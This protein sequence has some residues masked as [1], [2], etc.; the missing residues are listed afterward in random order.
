MVQE[1]LN[2][3]LVG[4]IYIELMIFKLAIIKSSEL[5]SLV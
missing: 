2:G 4:E 1:F 3:W 5:C